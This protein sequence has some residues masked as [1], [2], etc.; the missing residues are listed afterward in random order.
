LTVTNVYKV[1]KKVTEFLAVS[2]AFAALIM[3]G[4]ILQALGLLKG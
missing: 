1:G 2:G 4:P 3:A